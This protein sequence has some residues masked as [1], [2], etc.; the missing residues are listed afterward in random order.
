MTLPR[1]SG[2]QAHAASNR[3]RRL[4]ASRKR[5]GSS[6]PRR[7]KVMDTYSI[8]GKTNKQGIRLRNNCVEW[9]GLSIG[10]QLRKGDLYAR[11]ALAHKVKLC[12]ITRKFPSGTPER[13]VARVIRTLTVK[14]VYSILQ[15]KICARKGAY[16]HDNA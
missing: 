15:E 14:N 12:R 16:N 2:P 4:L 5:P 9:Q 1:P 10:V 3:R 8:S 7:D 13:A 6:C 11:A